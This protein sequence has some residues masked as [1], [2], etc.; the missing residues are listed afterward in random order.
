MPLAEWRLAKLHAVAD[1]VNL[2]VM[3]PTERL[4]RRRAAANPFVGVPL[5]TLASLLGLGIPYLYVDQPDEKVEDR[6][7]M[8]VADASTNLMV[9]HRSGDFVKLFG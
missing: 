9:S 3:S 6:Q 7:R 2:E 8:M 5:R 4:R 1:A